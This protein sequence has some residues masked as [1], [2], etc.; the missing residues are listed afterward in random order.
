MYHFASKQAHHKKYDSKSTKSGTATVV[1]AKH[2]VRPL[3][4]GC[5]VSHKPLIFHIS[6]WDS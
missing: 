1:T 4:V 6:K 2:P 3:V 5:S